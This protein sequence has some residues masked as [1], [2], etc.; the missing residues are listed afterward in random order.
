[1][2]LYAHGVIFF[3]FKLI[4][5]REEGREGEKHRW[6]SDWGSSPQPR[7]VP[8]LG[9]KRPLDAWDNAQPIGPHIQGTHGKIL[10]EAPEIICFS[11]SQRCRHSESTL[12]MAGVTQIKVEGRLRPLE[13]N[14]GAWDHL[15]QEKE[16]PCHLDPELFTGDLSF[17]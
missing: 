10:K 2:S 14:P 5:E 15:K 17:W 16:K 7:H 11:P 9:I 12:R 1:M 6:S 4:C 8:K 3:F 13:K